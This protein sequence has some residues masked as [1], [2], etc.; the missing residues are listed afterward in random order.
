MR[1]PAPRR[2]QL[3]VR[4]VDFSLSAGSC[5]HPLSVHTLAGVQRTRKALNST[6][7]SRPQRAAVQTVLMMHLFFSSLVSPVGLDRDDDDGSSELCQYVG[8]SKAAR[9]GGRRFCRRHA[10]GRRCKAPGC[11]KVWLPATLSVCWP[12]RAYAWPALLF[13]RCRDVM[14]LAAGARGIQR[15]SSCCCFVGT[16][17]LCSSGWSL[18][19]FFRTRTS[20]PRDGFGRSP[21]ATSTDLH[22]RILIFTPTSGCFLAPQQFRAGHA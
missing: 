10:E 14:P 11:T 21:S 3:V 22:K 12:S 15:N 18:F 17:G 8:C 5:F 13:R 16:G 6:A 2:F 4:P 7:P 19:C 1:A 20:R 9:S